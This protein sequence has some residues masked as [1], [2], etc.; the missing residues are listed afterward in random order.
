MINDITNVSSDGFTL[1]YMVSNY[2]P[3]GFFYFGLVIENEA[4]R[5]RNL[6]SLEEII[7]EDLICEEKIPQISNQ[8]E[9]YE[10]NGNKN[11]VL[12]AGTDVDGTLAIVNTVLA[13]GSVINVEVPRKFNFFILLITVHINFNTL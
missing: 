2:N 5:R 11:Y 6:N 7:G 12:Y 1:Y 3:N 4:N 13:E 10:L 8:I 9:N